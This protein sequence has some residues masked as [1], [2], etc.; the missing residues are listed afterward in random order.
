MKTVSQWWLAVIAVCG[1]FV[2]DHCV[3]QENDAAWKAQWIGPAQSSSNTWICFRKTFHLDAKPKSF[4][5][6]IAVDSKYWLWINGR[7]VVF[8][9]GLKRGP[10]PQDTYY[11]D[12]ELGAELKRGDNAIAVLVWHWGKDGFSHND[13]GRAGL[14]F[15]AEAN[16]NACVSD[17]SWKMIVHPAYG[18]TGPPFPNYRLPEF[19]IVFD[20]R[21]D[22]PE[23]TQPNFDDRQWSSPATFGTPPVAPWNRLE[24]RPIPLWK[25]HGLR[26]YDDVARSQAKDG[27]Q[28]LVAKLPYNAQ[29]TPWLEIDA[30][31]G[32]R[33][34][35][36]T[37]NYQGGSAPN[38]RSVYITRE[39]RQQ[40]ESLGWMNGHNVR[41]L[42]SAKVKFRSVKY[43]ETGYNADFI[44]EFHCDDAALNTLWEKAR[45]T[46]YVTMRDNYMDCPDR[47]RAQWW[48]DEVNE[49]GEAFYVLD[50][51]R[52]PLLARKGIRE[53][54][55]WQRADHTL[56]SPVPAG[57]PQPNARRDA[58]DGTWN[59]ELPVQMLAS[60]GFYGFWTYYLYSGDRDTIEVAY[61]HVREYL[62]IWEQ[63]ADGLVIHRKGD[64][65]WS[66]W[67]KNIDAKIL[68]ST[69]YY[70]ALKGAI[71]M[72]QVCGATT[73]IPEWER[74]K[75]AIEHR[76]NASFW[77]GREYRSAEYT[78]DTDD[79]A[80]AM[81][82]VAGLAK[83]DMYPDLRQVLAQHHNASPYMEKYVLEALYLMNASGDAA[84]RMKDRWKDQIESELTTLWEGWGL[85][86][87]GYGGGTYNHAWSGGALTALSQ[88]AAGIA[89]EQPAFAKFHVLPQPG[90]LKSIRSVVP[91][92]RGLIKLEFSQNDRQVQML[93]E[94]P[95]KATATLG[96]PQPAGKQFEKITANGVTVW[97][98]QQA[99]KVENVPGLTFQSA[100]DRFVQFKAQP[101]RWRLVGRLK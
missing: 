94:T 57:V 29:I 79:R 20:A 97:T 48:G 1:A 40:F 16:G 93:V 65:D 96:I 28:L 33:V 42:T 12:V 31:A 77:N 38:V 90:T 76:F 39:G 3:A 21:K 59:T 4:R 82:V 89:P 19:N 100:N 47:E 81:A 35:I 85:G 98:S 54:A 68:D 45:R 58:R 78:G 73:D 30:P 69:W 63:D 15:E 80:N 26:S 34:E 32:E 8:E 99:D 70:L 88:Y 36:Q 53:L 87:E 13:S 67:G 43:R 14:L 66:D 18:E 22:I 23:W 46:L 49:L 92:P 44:G 51:E 61:P 74:R 55:R 17:A 52:G 62:K 11:D 6:R 56:Y 37:D 7:Q 60:V 27:R 24:L 101:G 64:W 2:T 41:Y 10:T 91:T 86:A 71:G 25:D 5:A 9:G 83:P 95:D 50:A 72:A 75:A 84:A